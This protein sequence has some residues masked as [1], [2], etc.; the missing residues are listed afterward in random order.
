MKKKF[1]TI[2]VKNPLMYEKCCAFVV[3]KRGGAC[4]VISTDYQACKDHI[5]VKEGQEM[6]IEGQ[7]I[8]I[9][10]IQEII[11]T[12]KSKINLLKEKK[13][14]KKKQNEKKQNKER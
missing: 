5:F 7:V 2:V 12:E 13:N 4:L 11:I 6:E 9:T 10:G 8:D 1:K 14:I 3:K